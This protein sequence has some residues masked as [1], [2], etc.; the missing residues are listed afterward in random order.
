MTR[1]RYFVILASIIASPAM[2]RGDL[3]AVG[4]P[5]RDLSPILT[6]DPGVRSWGQAF[7]YNGASAIDRLAVSVA[8]GGPLVPGAFGEFDP[9]GSDWVTLL[10]YPDETP[11]LAA[12]SGSAMDSLGLEIWFQASQRTPVALNINTYRPGIDRPFER[13]R[14]E[15]DGSSW[16]IGAG[17]WRAAWSDI[18]PVPAPGAVLLG[19]SGLALVGWLKRRLA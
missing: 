15:F 4:D 16:T 8:Q 11:Y 3:V 18:V 7:V 17:Y 2:T 10:S 19:A 12:A 1:L 6:Q 5:L 14:A 9:I 13:F